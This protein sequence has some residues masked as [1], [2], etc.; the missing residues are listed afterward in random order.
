M[1]EPSLPTS[2]DSSRIKFQNIF[3]GIDLNARKTKIICTLGP[4]CWDIEN[5]IKMLDAGMNVARLNFS[6]GDHKTHG[7]SVENL[8]EALK[9]RPDKTCGIMLDTKGPEIRTGMLVDS[10]SIEL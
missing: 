9:Q 3:E 4:S 1:V 6:H 8:R 2:T 10:K 7:K 5:L